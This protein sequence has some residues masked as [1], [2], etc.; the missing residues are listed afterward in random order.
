MLEYQV[1]V[2]NDSLHIN[3]KGHS[4]Y[5]TLYRCEEIEIEKEPLSIKTNLPE[6]KL[7]RTV[8]PEIY[9]NLMDNVEKKLAPLLFRKFSKTC[10]AL[11][12]LEYAE[13]LEMFTGST[14]YV[15]AFKRIKEDIFEILI[16]DST[17]SISLPEINEVQFLKEYGDK[18]H[19]IHA[20]SS[21]IW[22]TVVR[23]HVSESNANRCKLFINENRM[24]SVILNG[25]YVWSNVIEVQGNRI[26]VDIINFLNTKSWE[27]VEQFINCSY[28][29]P[30]SPL[31][32][33]RK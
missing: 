30:W 32:V 20:F 31:K 4:R 7:S 12:D 16:I 11:K 18:P 1:K 15:V 29:K 5:H 6:L 33:I 14:N 26:I 22:K 23:I 3:S 13:S 9:N 17:E 25:K 19:S 28:S 2:F 8:E 24:N 10:I 27:P 21:A